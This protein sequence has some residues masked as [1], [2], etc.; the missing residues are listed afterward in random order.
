MT[1]EEI[2]AL[3]DDMAAEAATSGDEGLKPGLLYLRASLYGTEI[4]TETTSA[5]R[6]QRYRGVRVR[7]LREVETE[8]L[9]R[10]DVVAKGLD[11]GDFEDLTD[12]P[13]RVVI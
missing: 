2:D 3:L 7:V 11:I 1:K 6:G 8:V 13:P 12:A 9:T 5:V 10:A 4:R